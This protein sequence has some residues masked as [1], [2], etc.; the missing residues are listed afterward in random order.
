M[1]LSYVIGQFLPSS[2]LNYWPSCRKGSVAYFGFRH[3]R[4]AGVSSILLST[5]YLFLKRR[6]F[7]LLLIIWNFVNPSFIFWLHSKSERLLLIM[8]FLF[9]CWHECNNIWFALSFIFSSSFLWWHLTLLI[10]CSSSYMYLGYFFCCS[11]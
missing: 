8:I 9:V 3:F 2:N 5:G 10:P 11:G 1:E 7:R 4:K 6:L